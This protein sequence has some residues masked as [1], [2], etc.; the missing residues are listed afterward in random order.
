MAV[1][2][3]SLWGLV[4]FDS[5]LVDDQLHLLEQRNLQ[6]STKAKYIH[7]D[8]PVV[9]GCDVGR[10]YERGYGDVRPDEKAMKRHDNGVVLQK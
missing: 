4:V 9:G 7:K 8:E 1:S 5:A 6:N 2:S 3:S 10:F